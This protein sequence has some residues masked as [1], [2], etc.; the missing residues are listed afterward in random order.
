M[1]AQNHKGGSP[2]LFPILLD[3]QFVYAQSSVF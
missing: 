1:T 2:L 3:M